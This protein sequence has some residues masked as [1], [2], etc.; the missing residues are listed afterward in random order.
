MEK[1]LYS[2]LVGFDSASGDVPVLV[3]G[4]KRMNQSIQ[5]IKAIKGPEAVELWDK[6]TKVVPE[7]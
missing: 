4:E 7:K 2:V 1:G 3:V 5:I 6:L